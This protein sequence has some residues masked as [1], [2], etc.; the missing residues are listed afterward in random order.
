MNT[1]PAFSSF[2][3]RDEVVSCFFFSQCHSSQ[4]STSKSGNVCYK[5]KLTRKV[6]NTQQTR[7]EELL[8]HTRLPSTFKFSQCSFQVNRNK[9]L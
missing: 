4:S 7:V 1:T 3:G 9:V 8:S 2:G 6:L 5:I